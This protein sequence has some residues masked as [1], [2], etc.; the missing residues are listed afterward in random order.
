M[1]DENRDDET[2]SNAS[3][4]YED[5]SP[6]LKKDL[7]AETDFFGE[8][9]V[10]HKLTTY[11][12]ALKDFKTLARIHK[13]MDT[14]SFTLCDD[15]N[16]ECFLSADISNW[17]S[18]HVAF[19]DA[20][21]AT[22]SYEITLH[23]INEENLSS[24]HEVL[25]TKDIIK[26]QKITFEKFLLMEREEL[27][28]FLVNEYLFLWC[29]ISRIDSSFS[30]RNTVIDMVENEISDDI[31]NLWK[32]QLLTDVTLIAGEEEFQAHKCI[33]AARSPVFL[34]M[35]QTDMKENHENKVILNDA[36]PECL[37]KLLD[38]VYSDK[39]ANVQHDTEKLLAMADKYDIKGLK[40]IC[41]Q[42]LCNT[43]DA[44]TAINTLVW[45]DRYNV[46][47][48][49]DRVLIFIRSHMKDVL[50][51]AA[52]S[53]VLAEHPNLLKD[54]FYCKSPPYKRQKLDLQ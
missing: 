4:K 24:F 53:D 22:H 1:E 19:C 52:Y 51:T 23:V 2:Q 6:K 41:A 12:W 48:L 7:I 27:D 34:A 26:G 54:I 32:K 36:D 49:K 16:I 46:Q 31:P 15:S 39:V 33:L 25:Y 30:F 37:K 21:P 8:T 43:L 14:E 13:H 10:K 5:N 40:L 50:D 47:E 35:F 18:V 38:F 45:A 44:A 9:K 17:L 42:E 11:T 3:T 29:E 28:N 20:V